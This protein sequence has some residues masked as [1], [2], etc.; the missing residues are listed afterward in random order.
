MPATVPGYDQGSAATFLVRTRS[1]HQAL[2][3][4]PPTPRLRRPG[5]GDPIPEGQ[6][7]DAGALQETVK[8][9]PCVVYIRCYWQSVTI[10]GDCGRMASACVL[11]SGRRGLPAQTHIQSSTTELRYGRR[12]QS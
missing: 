6:N 4:M 2:Q 5:D 12:W 8:E 1:L 9:I 3:S 10:A 7:D 11:K